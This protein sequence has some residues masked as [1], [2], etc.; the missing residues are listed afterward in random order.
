MPTPPRPPNFLIFMTDQQRGDTVLDGSPYRALTPHLDAFRARAVTFTEAHCPSPHCCPSRTSFFTGEYPSRHGVWHNVNVDNALTR[1]PFPGTPFWSDCLRAAGYDLT[2]SGKWHVSDHDGPAAHGWTEAHVTAS[3]RHPRTTGP[4]NREWSRYNDPAALAS[5]SATP[6]DPGE[7]RRPGYPSFTLYGTKSNP[8]GDDDVVAAGCAALRARDGARSPWCHYIGTLGPHDPYTPPPAFLALYQDK[9]Y[10]LP[11]GFA[12]PMADK[13]GLYRRTRRTLAQL[14]PAE[15]AEALRY[16]LAFCTYEDHLFGLALATLAATDQADNTVVLFLSDHGDYRGDHGL[17]CKG[18]PCFRGAY[19]VPCVIGGAVPNLAVGRTT[20]APVSLVDFAPT[21]LELAGL[22]A[23]PARLEGA[24]SLTPWLH[25]ETPAEWRDALFTQS[26]GNELYSIQ[27]SITTERWKFV[28][29]GFDDDELYD[30][31][32][33]PHELHNL[34][35]DPAHRETVVALMTRLW[36]FARAH[37]D[38]CINPYIMVAHAPIGPGS[39]LT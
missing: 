31:A 4:V 18:L 22:P 17:W 26:N 29:N 11:P 38:T 28:Y 21:L 33:D 25:G 36:R 9:H 27:R 6:R 5:D 3:P 32:A 30:L 37:D 12:D 34:A 13:P 8:F 2:F 23:S 20:A 7:I 15:H 1:E 24:R 39:A 14:T 16:Y 35:A 10:D 19:H